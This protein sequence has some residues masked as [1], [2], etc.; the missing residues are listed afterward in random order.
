MFGD[1]VALRDKLDPE[2][3]FGNPYLTQ[4]LGS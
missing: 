1:F 4:V 2:R 3:R